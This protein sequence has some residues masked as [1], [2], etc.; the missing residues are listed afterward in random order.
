M[1]A[2]GWLMLCIAR[3]AP[4]M[5]PQEVANLLWGLAAGGAVLLE[6]QVQVSWVCAVYVCAVGAWLRVW[7]RAACMRVCL[8]ACMPVHPLAGP[9]HMFDVPV[10]PSAL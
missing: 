3:T 1:S 9:V 8:S 6:E 10:G 4:S 2:M 7:V 5:G